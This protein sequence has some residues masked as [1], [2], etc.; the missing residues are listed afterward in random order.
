MPFMRNLAEL[1][2]GEVFV[3][4]CFVI[5]LPIFKYLFFI[6]SLFQTLLRLFPFWADGYD[7]LMDPSKDAMSYAYMTSNTLVL[8]QSLTK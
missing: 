2:S 4:Y 5:C 7:I 8:L 3:V 1:Y 6:D